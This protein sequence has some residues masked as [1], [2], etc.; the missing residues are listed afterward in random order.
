[1]ACSTDYLVPFLDQDPGFPHVVPAATG[2]PHQILDL[3]EM[4]QEEM[5]GSWRT[6]RLAIKKYM[7]DVAAAA[8][9]LASE[10]AGYIRGTLLLC[11]W[12]PTRFNFNQN[13]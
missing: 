12:R 13:R 9:F 10:D 3:M 1:M 7:D 2:I 5:P 6:A 11:G 8:L 4:I